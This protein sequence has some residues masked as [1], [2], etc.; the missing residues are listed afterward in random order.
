LVCTAGV[1]EDGSWV[2]IYPVPF[3]FLEFKK[4]Q[5]V[6]LDLQEPRQKDFR[7]ESHS[8]A[9]PD[10]SDMVVVGELG[11]KSKYD[12]VGVLL[13]EV[14]NK[15]NRNLSSD[16]IIVFVDLIFNFLFQSVVC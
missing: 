16:F 5:W 7:P 11:T 3:K 1:R 10:L 12:A 15:T 9:K 14:R 2:R 13:H 4:Y 8:P 6:E